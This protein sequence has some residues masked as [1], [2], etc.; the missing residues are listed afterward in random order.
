MR[1]IARVIVLV[2]AGSIWP[3]TQ[4]LALGTAAAQA[5]TVGALEA[6]FGNDGADDLAVGVLGEN[7]DSVVDAGSVNVL[8]GSTGTGLSGIGSQLFTQPISAVEADDQFG[9]AL[10]AGDFNNDG[11]ADL[12]VGAPFE[13]VGSAVAAGAVNAVAES[14]GGL[15]G[16][17]LFTQASAGVPSVAEREDFFGWALAA[18]DPGTATTTAGSPSAASASRAR[19]TEAGC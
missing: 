3:A 15:G 11:F 1:R 5:A 14:T 10:A 19:R 7:V 2:L 17:L 16:G 8:Y 12:G 13:A 4:A 9:F 18:G 6:D